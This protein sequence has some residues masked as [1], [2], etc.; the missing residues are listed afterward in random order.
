MSF[1]SEEKQIWEASEIMKELERL[2]RQ[3][4]DL[5]ETPM[6]AFQPLKTADDA[7][8]D[9]ATNEEKLVDALDAIEDVEVVDMEDEEFMRAM[10]G[11]NWKQEMEENERKEQERWDSL[12]DEEQEMAEKNWEEVG[13]KSRQDSR[14]R[15]EVWQT[16]G[17]SYDQIEEMSDMDPM[18]REEYK[19]MMNEKDYI[20][21]EALEVESNQSLIDGLTKLASLLAS[22]GKITEAH[23]IEQ[24][25]MDIRIALREAKNG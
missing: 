11:E 5:F 23:K 14:R 7:W 12:S 2:A 3:N 16:E 19:N 22:E 20:D 15:Q 9:D 24:T 10:Y 8:E 4:P 1:S 17:P 18:E 6:E 13:K 25:L 21:V